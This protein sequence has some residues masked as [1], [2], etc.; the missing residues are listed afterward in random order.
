MK[1]N[2]RVELNLKIPEVIAKCKEAARLGIRDT[3]VPIT[4]DIIN[5]HPWKNRTGNN[6]RSIAMEVSG[7]GDNQVV[8]PDGTEG[9]VYSTSG[10]GGYLETGTKRNGYVGFPYFRPALDRHKDELIPNIKKHMP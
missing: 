3:L 4:S 9:A 1:L 5:I 8:D 6:M 10:Y 2:V 7:M